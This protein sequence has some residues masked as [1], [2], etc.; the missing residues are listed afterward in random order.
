M[1]AKVL[2]FKSDHP[3]LF[4]LSI[5][6]PVVLAL[7]FSGQLD[8]IQD[9]MRKTEKKDHELDKKQSQAKRD[10]DKIKSEAD[11]HGKK[12]EEIKDRDQDLDWHK[13]SK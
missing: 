9:L 3:I 11:E 10:S 4:W 8:S 6:I 12:V 7:L 1:F 13:R 5:G 2:K